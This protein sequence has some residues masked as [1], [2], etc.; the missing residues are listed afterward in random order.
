MSSA[1]RISIDEYLGRHDEPACELVAGELLPKPMG[2]IEHRRMERRL[3]QILARFEQQGLGEVVHEL[4]ILQGDDV[5]IPDVVFAP[6]GAHWDRGLL[7][8]PPVLCIEILSPS[9]SPRELFAKCEA[10]HAGG[11]PYCWI[12]DPIQDLAWEYHRSSPVRLV[13]Q[14]AS[15][16]AGAISASLAELFG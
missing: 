12:V 8:D 4:S 15:L 9:Q 14:P 2:T 1:A 7:A 5:R 6:P 13:S 3:V 10:H 16:Q 11:V